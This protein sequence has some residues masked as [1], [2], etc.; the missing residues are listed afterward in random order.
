MCELSADLF[1]FKGFRQ[2][3]GGIRIRMSRDTFFRRLTKIPF[4]VLTP[5]PYLIRKVYMTYI[6]YTHSGEVTKV[7]VVFTLFR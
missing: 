6:Y 3:K 2:T 4:F 5:P 1:F 7:R